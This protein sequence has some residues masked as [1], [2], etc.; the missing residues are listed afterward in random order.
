M[1]IPGGLFRFLPV[2]PDGVPVGVPDAEDG[3][4]HRAGPPGATSACRGTHGSTVLPFGFY[5]HF[6]FHGRVRA[7]VVRVCHV[8]RRL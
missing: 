3:L 1:C 6:H 8:P 7:A 4:A 2:L 5:F